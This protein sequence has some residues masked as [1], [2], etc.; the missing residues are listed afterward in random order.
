MKS[1]Y[2]SVLWLILTLCVN[3][4]AVG[5]QNFKVK[6]SEVLRHYSQ[7][8]SDSL[9]YKAALFLID[10]IEYHASVMSKPQEQYYSLLR[11]IEEKYKYPE[12]LKFIQMAAKKFSAADGA[13]FVRTS[14]F[15]V[16]TSSYLIEN[17]DDAFEKWQNGNFAKHLNFDEFCEYLLPYKLT[18]EQVEV[19]RSELYTQYKR[20]LESI[21]P[22]DDK[23]Y[24]A[25]W[26]ASQINDIIK[27]DK[28]FIHNVPYIGN[29]N[30]PVSVL[31]NLRMGNCNDYAFKATYVMRA[32]GIPVCVDF[33]PQWPTRPHGHHW[34]VVLDNSGKNIPFM[35]A[36]SNPG[37]PCKDDYV[38]GKIYRYTY[39]LQKQSLAFLNKKY[40][41]E[42]PG[43]LNSPFI[44]DVTTEYTKGVD[45]LID[46]KEKNLQSHHFAYLAVFNNQ[47]WV[48]IAYAEVKNE[49]VNFHNV[50]R[51]TVYLPV[52]WHH[53]ASVPFDYP[54]YVDNQGNVK[55]LKPNNQ[56][57]TDICMK[58]KYPVFSRI[59]SFSKRMCEAKFDV[60]DTDGFVKKT[61]IAEIKKNPEMMWDSVKVNLSG[62]KFRYLRYVASRRSH[63]NVAELEFYDGN[64]KVVPLSVKTDGMEEVGFTGAEVLDGNLLTYYESRKSDYSYLDFDF[65]K[66]I[67]LSLIKYMPR[68]DDNY[69]K[70]GHLYSLEYFDKNGTITYPMVKAD[71]DNVTFKDVP[72]DALYILHDLTKG[73]EERIFQYKDGRPI[74]F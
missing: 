42:I 62:E 19:W 70:P 33:T 6:Y 15:E 71:Q 30:L 63:C 47:K 34:N 58:R 12:C 32:C 41:E 14:D 17:I 5:D 39:A 29:V 54:I 1:K 35:G 24:S 57:K 20:G 26:G 64:E 72:A 8:L 3:A 65:G 25:Y 51:G 59:Y 68:N 49:R 67:S 43:V 16:V 21:L 46:L 27:Q 36:E 50:G 37:Y 31:K 74:W 48:P 69:V 38:V 4:K 66:P 11:D 55:T 52:F 40:K 13:D 10:N 22:V 73:T 44:K 61:T 18:N 28:I 53:G 45:I 23:K 9:K 60:S 56:D 2:I 7:N